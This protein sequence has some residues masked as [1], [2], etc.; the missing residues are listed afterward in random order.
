MS[1]LY[2]SDK[3]TVFAFCYFLIMNSYAAK[4]IIIY[5]F[6]IYHLLFFCKSLCFS[7]H[8]PCLL[9]FGT[10]QLTLRKRVCHYSTITPY[11][12]TLTKPYSVITLGY[13]VQG[14]KYKSGK[15]Y[16]SVG[17]SLSRL[18]NRNLIEF[19][20]AESKRCTRLKNR[21]QQ[22]QNSKTKNK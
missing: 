14:D 21:P 16:R 12:Y 13:E 15:H 1:S 18:G 9:L 19:G 3:E 10:Y 6:T 4:I 17:K 2:I 7:L 5:H 22:K 11:Y 8:K 20:I